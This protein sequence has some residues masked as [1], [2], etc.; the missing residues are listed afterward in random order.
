MERLTR[1][2]VYLVH[3]FINTVILSSLKVSLA[4]NSWRA[5]SRIHFVFLPVLHTFFIQRGSLSCSCNMQSIPHRKNT[6]GKD[7]I[8]VCSHQPLLLLCFLQYC[9]ETHCFQTV[10]ME[11]HESQ[12]PDIPSP[13]PSPPI[14]VATFFS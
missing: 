3:R 14:H 5:C 1:N 13:I 6:H 2:R 9:L 10:S 12:F 4:S 11:Q 7:K 8:R